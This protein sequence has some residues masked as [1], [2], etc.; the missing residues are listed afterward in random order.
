MGNQSPAH[1]RGE[2]DCPLAPM[3]VLIIHHV[4]HLHRTKQSDTALMIQFLSILVLL[5]A[6]GYSRVSAQATPATG[7]SSAG[8]DYDLATVKVN[9]TG[10]GSIHVSIRDD[11]LQAT[12]VQLASSL[13]V[14]FDIRQDQVMSLPRW[15]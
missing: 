3:Q 2:I 4:D 5:I 1:L 10:I 14:A 12:N 8:T 15:A 9:N 11:T 13:E 7:A 6:C